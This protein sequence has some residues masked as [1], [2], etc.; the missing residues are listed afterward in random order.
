MQ[1]NLLA[2]QSLKN[3]TNNSFYIFLTHISLLNF[4]GPKIFSSIILISFEYRHGF[5]LN[6]TQIISRINTIST[7]H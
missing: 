1:K 2:F 7:L 3:H 4:N 5:N 6:N